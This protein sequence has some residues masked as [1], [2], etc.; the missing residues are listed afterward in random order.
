MVAFIS[1]PEAPTGLTT[2]L[3]LEMEIN[4]HS[5]S[6]TTKTTDTLTHMKCTPSQKSSQQTSCLQSRPH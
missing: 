2:Q 3:R 5:H 1:N 6:E 4:Q